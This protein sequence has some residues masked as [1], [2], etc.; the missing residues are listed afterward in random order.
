MAI[1]YAKFREAEFKDAM[2]DPSRNEKTNSSSSPFAAHQR[3]NEDMSEEEILT[4]A[5]HQVGHD[6]PLTEEQLA[7]IKLAMKI[8]LAKNDK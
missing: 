7:Q 5:A 8:A 4:L 6:G 2:T 3:E 1:A